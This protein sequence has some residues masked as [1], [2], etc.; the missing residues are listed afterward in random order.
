MSDSIDLR[1]FLTKLKKDVVPALKPLDENLD[2]IL[3]ALTALVLTTSSGP[4]QRPPNT[5]SMEARIS[6]STDY[7][8]IPPQ[9]FYI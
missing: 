4:S 2:P 3:L 5:L 9:E 8:S 6:V 1:R 7:T